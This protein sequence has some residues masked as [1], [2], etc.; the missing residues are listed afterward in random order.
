MKT[1]SNV[2]PGWV[3]IGMKCLFRGAKIPAVYH[4]LQGNMVSYERLKLKGVTQHSDVILILCIIIVPLLVMFI[5][6][7]DPCL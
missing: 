6:R 1:P 2:M 4:T 3:G 7:L 5:F